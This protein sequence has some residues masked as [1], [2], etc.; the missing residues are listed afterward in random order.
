MR[1][2]AITVHQVKLRC[3]MALETIVVP[4]I[5]DPF[6][7]GRN[8]RRIVRALAIGEGAQRTVRD[9][10]FIDFGIE[11]GMIRFGMSV[12]GDQEELSIWSPGSERRTELAAAIGEAAVADLPRR[13]AVGAHHEDL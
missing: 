8:H 9:A 11:E 10:E 7:V 3:L 5:R 1:A 2:G 4:G 13:A 12:G 6:A